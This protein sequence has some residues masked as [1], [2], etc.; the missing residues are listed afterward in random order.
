[1]ATPSPNAVLLDSRQIAGVRIG[2]VYYDGGRASYL[3]ELLDSEGAR[4]AGRLMWGSVNEDGSIR[5]S[6]HSPEEC[7]TFPVELFQAIFQ[8]YEVKPEAFAHLVPE[9]FWLHPVIMKFNSQAELLEQAIRAGC[10]RERHRSFDP[11]DFINDDIG[12]DFD[13]YGGPSDGYGGRLDD[14]FINDALDGNPDA[15]W[16]ID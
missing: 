7:A 13:E 10:Q 4:L 15:Y 16:N 9:G 8:L 2:D 6:W 14:D 3:L 11:D 1:M 5:W 12:S